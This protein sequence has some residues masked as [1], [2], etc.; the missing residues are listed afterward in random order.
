[1][2]EP[3]NKLRERCKKNIPP[4]VYQTRPW[5]TEKVK[6]RLSIY[7]TWLLLHTPISANGASTIVIISGLLAGIFF[8]FGDPFS[9]FIGT[10]FFHIEYL[11]DGVDGEIARYKNSASFSGAY[12]DGMIHY[13]LESYQFLTIGIGLHIYLNRID[14]IFLGIVASFSLIILKITYDLKYKYYFSKIFDPGTQ[15]KAIKRTFTIKSSNLTQNNHTYF[16][17]IV[18]FITL[19]P[20]RIL[21]I[22][23]VAVIDLFLYQA[24]IQFRAMYYLLAFYVAYFPLVSAKGIINIVFN[25]KIDIEFYSLFS[26]KHSDKADETI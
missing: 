20:N 25:K 22:T 2:V 9:C 15:N 14:P 6:R 17:Y 21:V 24:E 23:A 16:Y 26:E 5:Y 8:L 12:F 4:E 19:N 7:I 1:M 3:I 13:I 10:I 11:F 18:R